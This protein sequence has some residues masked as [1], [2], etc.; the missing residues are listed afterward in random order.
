MDG[1][2]RNIGLQKFNYANNSMGSSVYE[3]SIIIAKT[4][5]SHDEM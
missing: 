5:M 1:L 3:F 2:R 4:L